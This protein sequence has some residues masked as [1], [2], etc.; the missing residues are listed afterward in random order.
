MN[1]IKNIFAISFIFFLFPCILLNA[2]EK[3]AE[4]KDCNYCLKY[5]KLL[6]WPLED[7]PLAFIYQENI[8]YPKGMFGSEGKMKAAGQK[9]SYRF[10]KKKKDLGKKPGPMIMDMA[11]FE[12]LINEM[13]N[14]PTSEV[15]KIEKLMKVRLTFR[16][17]LGISPLA[18]S[19]EAI[20]KF[21]SLGKMMRSAKK[22]K[23]KV[24]EELLVRK[25]AL[26]ELKSKIVLTK[27]A[28]KVSETSKK[29]EEVKAQ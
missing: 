11:Y 10:V 28:V 25:N 1:N 7:R 19:E 9:I 17:S 26:Q 22:K 18:T 13:L 27:Q 6:D 5:E 12:V 24:D 20:L 15:E 4:E 8:K 29:I 21:Y 23:Q 14:K 3:E 16:Q 2:E